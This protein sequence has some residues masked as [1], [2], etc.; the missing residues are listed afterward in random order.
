M[1]RSHNCNELNKTHLNQNV[2]LSGWVHRRRD[3][4][5]ILFIDLRD[6][7][8]ITQLIFTNQNLELKNKATNTRYESIVT[9]EGRVLLRHKNKINTSINTGEIEIFVN[10]YIIES[11]SNI[12]PLRV[13]S[14]TDAPEEIRLKYRFLDL[15]RTKMHN[16]I[17]LR[18]HII[19]EFRSLMKERGFLELQTPILTSSSPE[20]AR[21]FLVP[22]RLYPGKFYALPQAPQQFKQILMMSGFDKYFQIAPC[23]R[24]EDA[25]SDRSPGEFYQLD[26]E[27][28]FVTQEDIFS[29][30]E[31]VLYKVFSKFSSKQVS[32]PPFPRI[33]YS[34]AII[35][36]ASDKPDI[37]NPLK[38]SDITR[39]FKHSTLRLFKK[40]I[41]KG[42]VVLAIPAPYTTNKSRK[43]FTSITT[44]AIN[45][46][47]S[48]LSHIQ[49]T[50]NDITKGPIA[51]FFTKEQLNIIKQTVGINYG[52]SIFFL[53]EKPQKSIQLANK[54]RTKLGHELNLIK[55]DRFEFCW[56]TDFPLYT[57][58]EQ[59]GKIDFNHNP[60]SMP[61]GGLQALE[62]AKTQQE[63]LSLKAFQYDIVCNGI[64]L[65]SGAIRN[66]KLELLYKVFEIAGYDKTEVDK[67]FGSL[68]SAFQFGA[69]AHGGIAPGI[70]RIV[71][72]I[73]GAANLREIT[74]FPMNQQ[75]EDILMR[76]P[77]YPHKQQLT[78][79]HFTL[80]HPTSLKNN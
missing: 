70:D 39:I 13:N 56:I 19:S 41:S 2:K 50:Q 32:K 11:E 8:G 16:N 44:F 76:A 77:N 40:E 80:S 79:I 72:L 63:L 43:F 30:I 23:F 54:I 46:G 59:T 21:D 26:I 24:D 74:A 78:D 49:F 17:I 53:C 69:P 28:S 7:Y 45:E 15:R 33:P 1:L 3:H 34:Q 62:N 31:P 51:K 20:G 42:S 58:N 66:H 61:Q 67:K 27:M 25:R 55:H 68:T 71:M 35:Q 48:G 10:N 9:I 65:S 60:F 47:A 5:H 18:S 14:Y 75:A 22:S 36:Y 73:A 6:H 64:E 29:T 38:I 4:G 12:L 57:L 52:D 37:R